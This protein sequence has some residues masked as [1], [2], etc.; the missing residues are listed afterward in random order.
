M[1]NFWVDPIATLGQ[2]PEH[3]FYT[4]NPTV[5]LSFNNLAGCLTT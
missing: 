4:H 2:G 1:K 5:R 3:N